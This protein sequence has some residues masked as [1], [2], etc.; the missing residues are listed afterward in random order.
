LLA[1]N[2][3]KK[4]LALADMLLVLVWQDSQ[5]AFRARIAAR[6][7]MHERQAVLAWT[8]ASTEADFIADAFAH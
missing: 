2:A 1:F 5:S 4:S 3:E 8:V 7:T 6:D